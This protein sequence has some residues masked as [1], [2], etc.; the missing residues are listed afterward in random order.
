VGPCA[1]SHTYPASLSG[2]KAR[3]AL[4]AA[5]AFLALSGTARAAWYG[6]SW[7]Y[8]KPVVVNGALVPAAQVSIPVLVSLPS[9]GDLAARAQD[10]GDDIL[11]TSAD[12]TTKLAHEIESFNGATGALVAWVNVPALASGANTTIHLYYGNSGATNQ[13]DATGVWDAGFRGVWHLEEAVTDNT[14]AAA[15]HQ[16]STLNANHG[17]QV[18]NNDVAAR[19]GPGQDLEGDL[20]D[21]YVEIPNSPS[22][23]NVQEGDYTLE[24]W[25]NP[26]TVPPGV[27][28][29][30][31]SLFAV[32]SKEGWNLGLEFNDLGRFRANHWLVG[33]VN[34]GHSGGVKSPGAFHHVAV[35]VSR[36]AG[37]LR[38]YVNGVDEGGSAFAPGTAAREYG[39]APWRIGI[40]A[41]GRGD[42]D[43]P[44]DAKIDEVRISAAARSATWIQTEYNNQANQGVGAGKFI[45][46]LGPEI[47]DSCPLRRLVMVTGTGDF[48]NA[49][50][51]ARQA[52]F[53]GLGYT[54][55]A[56]DDTTGDYATAAANNDVM[57]ISNT[58]SGSPAGLSAR[59]LAIGVVAEN[60]NSWSNL[61]YGS[62]IG[63]SS[64]A[65]AVEV[66]SNAH[67]ITSTL[68]LGSNAIYS[69]S[70]ATSVY[71]GALPPGAQV[72]ANQ[73]AQ[74]G[75][76][77]VAP[78]GASLLG[79]NVAADARVLLGTAGPFANWTPALQALMARSVAWANCGPAATVGAHFSIAHDGAGPT[80][81]AEPVTLTRHD[82]SHAVD[83]TW[84]GTVTLSTSTGHG[85]WSLVSGSGTLVNSGNGNGTY[86]YV[87]GDLGR[88]V[89]G[90]NPGTYAERL[91]VN[92]TDG[93]VS[94]RTGEDPSLGFGASVRDE[95]QAAAYT[96]Q[97]GSASWTSDWI[98]GGEADGPSA[99][100][101][102]V[103]G[104]LALRLGDTDRTLERQVDL[105]SAVSATLRFRY[106][107][108]LGNA[109]PNQAYVDVSAN[110]GGSWTLA[111]LTLTG[112][113]VPDASYL[114]ATVDL[115]P[116]R[117]ANTRIRFR[118]QTGLAA[119]RDV[120]LVDVNVGYS[121][122]P[123][124]C[125]ASS[126]AYR[127][128]LTLAQLTDPS[129]PG[130]V[131]TS[132]PVLVRFASDSSLRSVANG[133][134]VASVVGVAPNE[135]PYDLVFTDATG[136]VLSHEI[137]RYTAAT[138][139]LAAWVKV[140]ALS[141]TATTAVT[142][143]YGNSYVTTPTANPTAVWTN[144]YAGVWHL[145]ESPADGTAG[146]HV[147]ATSNTNDGTPLN[148]QDG[149]GGTTNA[150][151]AIDGADRFAQGGTP[152]DVIRVPDH[153]TLTPPGD[154]SYSLWVN[155]S[156][157][158]NSMLSQKEHSAAPFFSYQTFLTGS[159]V[160]F[161][162]VNAAGTQHSVYRGAALA[163]GTWYHVVGV[164]EGTTVRIYVN[165][166]NAGTTTQTT[167]GTLLDSSQ[168]LNIGNR[169]TNLCPD[170]TLDEV[171]LSNVARSA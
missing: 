73:T 80:C 148:F 158:T 90:L 28:P 18:N 64:T 45:L 6:P 143:R 100:S 155:F 37:T 133:G 67:Y 20:R 115:T 29:A 42:F 129:C 83:T 56:I 66:V 127:R 137:E 77:V 74:G 160:F 128:T 44:A 119:T 40:V 31:N 110:G 140:P 62:S 13:Q 58:A 170:A 97:D 79:G 85:D 167:T 96:N 55:T 126:Y 50:D 69:A 105:S 26:D 166:T 144:G 61:F 52:F 141:T 82:A 38:L 164:H 49:E 9:D 114:N 84:T 146:G 103:V 23:E 30:Y 163:T 157:L 132:F 113:L 139:E 101:V 15:V 39:T 95:F 135:Q 109:S 27:Y 111:V 107:R 159:Q 16:D 54:V 99:G 147:D 145:A 81:A 169:V 35:V 41:P 14:T 11:F 162:W 118:T 152:N 5:L 1:K 153:A 86:T 53:Q 142:L 78:A 24:A 3:T 149:S 48:S 117:A 154:M 46:S 2:A 57:F 72:L 125:S 33:D 94:E 19:I 17:T 168:E 138:G 92:V 131:P 22:L 60:G 130:N 136:A 65:T 63:S 59:P 106:K 7:S 12:G 8:R 43:A 4:V 71:S 156:S 70:G 93:T 36:T 165:G 32:I 171:R 151:G 21:E 108:S 121:N 112:T 104:D 34:V 120:W 88:V 161:N 134:H 87:A 150:T 10:D 51:A 98:E 68:P 116:Y 89:L 47:A 25:F 122:A 76:L 124:G 75:Y 102:H 91:S 123:G